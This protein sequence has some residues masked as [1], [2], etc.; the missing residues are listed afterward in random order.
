VERLIRARLLPSQIVD[1]KDARR[2]GAW[3]VYSHPFGFGAILDV[4]AAVLH[5]LADIYEHIVTTT[6]EGAV[7]V[8]LHLDRDT[9]SVSVQPKR[10]A[11]ATLLIT[12]KQRFDLHLRVPAWA[13]RASVRLDLAGRA[14]PLRWKG[15]FLI[16]P[17]SEVKTGEVITLR[18]DLPARQ[19]V[20]EMPISHRK[21][22]LTWRGD[23]IV[24]CDPTVPIYPAAQAP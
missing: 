19:T 3:G 15:S 24:A 17:G 21:Y 4:F 6:P 12:P 22:A 16:V 14:L 9:P 23:E 10:D 8:N 20:E 11:S 5:S 2:D 7:M 13:P 18:H 1:G